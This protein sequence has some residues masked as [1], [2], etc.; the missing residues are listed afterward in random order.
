MDSCFMTT[1]PDRRRWLLATL[2]ACASVA[3]RGATRG[4]E[5]TFIGNFNKPVKLRYLVWVPETGERPAAGWPLMIFLHGS[6]ERGV[7]LSRVTTNGPPEQAVAGRAFPFILVAPQAERGDSWDSDAIEALRA[8][9]VSA[10]PIDADRVMVTGLSMGG[11]GAWNYAASY[12]D[13]VAAIAP[14]S[15]VGDTERARRVARVPVWAF[16]GKLD[17]V[18]PID[19]DLAM[20][21]A[22]R[23]VGG[24]CR[25]TIYPDT[26][27]DAWDQAYDDDTGL[28]DWLLRQRRGQPAVD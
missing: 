10:H 3:A 14:V 8:D 15:G 23:R 13:R 26:G 1:A 21:A 4:H 9:L 7:D 24:W 6:G 20:V 17:D 27:H 5:E 28:Y 12:P 18:V 2:A 25:F 16:H 11:Y 22:V 19:G